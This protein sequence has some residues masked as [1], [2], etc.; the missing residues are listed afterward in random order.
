[1]QAATG[2]HIF[3]V[4]SLTVPAR[5]ITPRVETKWFRMKRYG[6]AGAVKIRS[7]QYPQTFPI[8]ITI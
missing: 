7:R 2:G 5:R 3:R 1:M 6:G 4:K 8:I